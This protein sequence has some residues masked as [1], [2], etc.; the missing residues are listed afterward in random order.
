MQIVQAARVSRP[1]V[2][3]RPGSASRRTAWTSLALAGTLLL[4]APAR[5]AEG[6][7][8]TLNY[9]VITLFV[10][11]FL[12][13]IVPVNRFIFQPIFRVLDAREDRIG[14]ARRR[15]EELSQ[16]AEQTLARYRESL[17]RAREEAE[18]DRRAQLDEARKEQLAIATAA[19]EEA[20]TEIQRGRAAI[21]DELADARGNLRATAEQ[22]AHEAASR[23]LGR[24]LS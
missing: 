5:A 10:V 17:Q 23:I 7:D 18:V 13:L 14:G 6:L 8:L 22:L 1:A 20:D 21:A 15:S 3:R 24:T 11:A 19:R 9:P 12:L 2:V 4:A 16:Q